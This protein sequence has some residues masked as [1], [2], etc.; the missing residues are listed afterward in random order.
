MA[1]V[2]AQIRKC[3]KKI[4]QIEHLESLKRPLTTEE[5]LKITKK[6][7]SRLE[8]K[9]LL[10]K[11]LDETGGSSC[12]LTSNITNSVSRSSPE[13]IPALSQPSATDPA[14][15]EQLETASSSSNI[16]KCERLEENQNRDDEDKRSRI[17]TEVLPED[18]EQSTVS[19]QV[20]LTNDYSLTLQSTVLPGPSASEQ[21]EGYRKLVNSK[22]LVTSLE[23][24]SDIIW[25]VAVDNNFILS[26][27][28]D[29]TVRVWDATKGEELSNLRGHT[30]SV[31]GVLLLCQ[32]SSA[33]LA[34]RLDCPSFQQLAV[35]CALDCYIIVWSI[36]NGQLLKSVY[37][38]NGITAVGFTENDELF[39]TGTDGGKVE[40]WDVV[41]GEVQHSIH[42]HEENVTSI[43]TD[44]ANQVFTT[45]VDG[46]LKVWNV[47][48]RHLQLLYALEEES[49]RALTRPLRHSLKTVVSYLDKL[50]LGDDSVS[51]KILDWRN[52]RMDR[53]RNSVQQHGS[54]DALCVTGNLLLASS[55][56]LDMGTSSINLFRLPQGEYLSSFTFETSSRILC[57]AS[58]TNYD[59]DIRIVTGGSKLLMWDFLPNNTRQRQRSPMSETIKSSYFE[60]LS[61]E[62]EISQTEE[63][64]TESEL[65]DEDLDVKNSSQLK[66]SLVSG[67][68]WLTSWCNIL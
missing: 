50:Y 51:I 8:L 9:D 43:A 24:H 23:G 58:T 54:T 38:Y 7:S 67:N 20:T 61:E 36:P 40:L 33:A 2:E 64:D 18:S 46:V 53:L 29:T 41:S 39:V 17:S 35:S 16:I 27:S 63:E 25:S 65:T 15:L 26:A 56:N 37:T 44:G 57:L 68:S 45:S 32:Q 22:F 49:S 28:R 13:S 42:G 19:S 14:D 55:Y 47:K 34:V 31:T 6:E 52:G 5:K 62:A 59:G 3:R 1:S 12:K 48:L 60:K 21:E 10:T 30:S 4:R 11:I 66:A